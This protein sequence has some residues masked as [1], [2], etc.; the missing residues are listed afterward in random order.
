MLSLLKAVIPGLII[1]LVVS[2]IVGSTGSTGGVLQIAHVNIQGHD[3]Y[4]SWNL[5]FAATGLA[6]LLLIMMD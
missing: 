3:V 6:W 1:T 5:F 2:A 4:G